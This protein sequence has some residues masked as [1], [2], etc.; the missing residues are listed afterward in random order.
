MTGKVAL[1]IENIRALSAEGLALPQIAE[2]LQIC[3]AYIKVLAR[4]NDIPVF[5]APSP[6]EV[7]LAALR[8]LAGEG[9]TY[10]QAADRL[11]LSYS[12]VAN[13][14]R[15]HGIP[16]V[17]CVR[18]RPRSACATPRTRQMAALYQSGKT[19]Q[20]IGNQYGVTRERIRQLIT[21]FHGLRGFDGG[22]HKQAHEKRAKFEAKRN[23]R[24]LR[25]WGCNWDQYLLLRGIT[26]QRFNEQK[27][28][29]GT[30]EIGWELNLWQWWSIWQQSGKWAQRGRGNGYVMCRVGDVG[31]YSIDNVFIATGCENTSNQSR[32]KSGLPIGVQR[33][34]AKH[35]V[36]YIAQR[37]IEGVH[38]HLGS[39]PT[40]E[41][42][43]AAYLSAGAQ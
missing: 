28:N 40:P 31:P 24:S 23:A 27:R 38:H 10:R 14:S 33:S 9:L 4:A 17:L 34:H 20:E 22:K 7:K 42:A 13:L 5:K 1:N 15:K 3:S 35:I 2:R 43:Y 39:H 18:G 19:L 26:I 21:K 30:R 8:D 12:L 25:R 11:G 36:T 16:L 37:S 41:L 6:A 29:A 32:K